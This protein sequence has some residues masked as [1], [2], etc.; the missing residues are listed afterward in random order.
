MVTP[1]LT[2][3]EIFT[4]LLAVRHVS[5]LVGLKAALT[6]RVQSVSQVS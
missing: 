3:A 6:E 4:E 2:C 1:T 5:S